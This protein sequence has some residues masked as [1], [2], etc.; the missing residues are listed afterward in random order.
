[1]VHSTRDI[2]IL[3]RR[4]SMAEYLMSGCRYNDSQQGD[5]DTEEFPIERH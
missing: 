1:M 5:I 2:A 3:I 4:L